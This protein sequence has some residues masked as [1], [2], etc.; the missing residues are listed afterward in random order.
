MGWGGLTRQYIHLILTEWLRHTAETQNGHTAELFKY[1][2][3]I[4]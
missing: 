2:K 4:F 1:D 3:Q